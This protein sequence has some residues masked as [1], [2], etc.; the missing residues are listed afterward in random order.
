MSLTRPL[1][2]LTAA[3]MAGKGL[4]VIGPNANDT[5]NLLGGYVNQHPRFVTTVYQ[6]MVDAY[7]HSRVHLEPACNSTAC[8]ILDPA[9]LRLARS[10]ACDVVVLV[11]GLTAD[12]R[13]SKESGT[14]ACGCKHDDSVEGEC[15]DRVG[16]ALPGMQQALLQ[17]VANIGKPT[18]LISVNAGMVDLSWALASSSV[19]VVINSIYQGMTTGTALGMTLTGATNPAA[20]LPISYYRNISD[21]GGL[22]EYNMHSRTYRYSRAE[23][24]RPFGFGLGFSAFEY[25]H[26][27]VLGA[28]AGAGE[29][30]TRPSA[31]RPSFAP[32]DT[33]VLSVAVRNTGALDGDEV[34]QV[35]LR[36]HNAS[37]TVP[38][39]QLVAF[40]RTAVPAGKAPVTVTFAIR[41][42]YQAVMRDPDF[43]PVVEPGIRELW[44]GGS[45]DPRFSPGVSLSYEV[46]GNVAIP[47]SQCE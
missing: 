28:E 21:T 42:A 26:G 44:I 34:V 35:Y 27:M 32:C 11:L 38:N 15:C 41:P 17:D 12:A 10:T 43:V 24:V 3:A 37:V 8:P 29:S 33:V 20:R 45:S 47:V 7:P 46:T 9:A 30:A 23:V 2:P 22:H 19:A 36:I 13:A 25:S 6:G 39:I 40:N 1:L 31:V 4:C 5:L 18:I 16:V 14:N